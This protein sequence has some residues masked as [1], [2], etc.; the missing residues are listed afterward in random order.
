MLLSET[1]KDVNSE[2]LSSPGRRSACEEQAFMTKI[3]KGV[4]NTFLADVCQ[5]AEERGDLTQAFDLGF[6]ET[7]LVSD[8]DS[9]A[10][11]V[12]ET[13]GAGDDVMSLPE[14]ADRF[15]ESLTSASPLYPFLRKKI[16]IP[17]I[18]DDLDS[19]T[20]GDD[21]LISWL[22][23]HIHA[24]QS[25]LASQKVDPNDFDY[26]VRLCRELLAEMTK[27][28]KDG[29][30]GLTFD[31][32]EGHAARSL[33]DVWRDRKANCV[34]FADLFLQAS[35]IA[36]IPVEPLE[37]YQDANGAS[38]QHVRIGLRN[39]ATSSVEKIVDLQSGYFSDPIPGE[40]WTPISKRELLADYYNMRGARED[41]ATR[42]EAD[43]DIALQLNPHH[44]LILFN[45]A[46]YCYRR[47]DLGAA[48]DLL[49]ASIRSNPRY[50]RAYQN[51]IL[52]AGD[53]GDRKLASWA[54]G[55]RKNL[56]DP[57]F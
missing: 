12:R 43:I 54:E 38:Q 24:I 49:L 41:D 32:D 29:G 34:E 1:I 51:L 26:T 47:E 4:E 52:V 31:T 19:T 5:A 18:A 33:I 36:G 17:W 57:E 23:D 3:C 8:Q 39:P 6:E 21:E 44:Y 46:Y 10:K 14:A 22:T 15:L 13:A 45:K 2:Q 20:N 16:E 25:D 7:R 48:K 28:A 35:Q 40:L 53:L 27:P 37:L 42:A 30:L 9:G 11:I 50:A 55:R 56:T